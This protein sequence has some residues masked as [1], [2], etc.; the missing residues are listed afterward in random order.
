MAGLLSNFR[1]TLT[2]SVVL[3]IL[4][5]VG[6]AMAA[7][8]GVDAIFFQEILKENLPLTNLIDSNFSFMTNKLSRFYG[9]TIKEMTQQPKKAVLPEDSHRG[10]ILGMAAVMASG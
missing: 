8:G 5:I 2:L 3:A 1:N 7:P 4:M 10:G 6:F 9:L